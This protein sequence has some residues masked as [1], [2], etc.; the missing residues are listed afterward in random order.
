[1]QAVKTKLAKLADVI[2]VTFSMGFSPDHL[3]ISYL[4]GYL[5]KNLRTDPCKKSRNSSVDRHFTTCHWNKE[6]I[7]GPKLMVHPRLMR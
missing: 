5:L 4:K 1:M 3:V 6:R 2:Q 7:S